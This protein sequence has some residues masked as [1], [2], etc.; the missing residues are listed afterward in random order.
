MMPNEHQPIDGL[1]IAAIDHWKVIC[2]TTSSNHVT[3]KIQ[4][5][6]HR[7]QDFTFSILDIGDAEIMISTVIGQ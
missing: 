2:P 7:T 4:F 3:Q 5:R 6:A 1:T